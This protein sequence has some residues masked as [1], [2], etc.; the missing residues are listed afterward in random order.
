MGSS[1]VE[2]IEEM[3]DKLVVIKFNGAS[4]TS[5]GFSGPKYE[6]RHTLLLS[7]FSRL[8][9]FIFLAVSCVLIMLVCFCVVFTLFSDA[10]R[11]WKF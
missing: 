7:A 11:L 9:L 1:D 6:L 2:K 3:L 5:M 8:I 10:G 4:G